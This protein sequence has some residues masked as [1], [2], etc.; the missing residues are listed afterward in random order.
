MLHL[1][2]PHYERSLNTDLLVGGN[3]VK[4]FSTQLLNA[5]RPRLARPGMRASSTVLTY[6]AAG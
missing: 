5:S 6:I 4:D 1:M 2:L 3:Q